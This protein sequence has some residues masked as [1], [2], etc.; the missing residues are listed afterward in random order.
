MQAR[1]FFEQIPLPSGESALATGPR[2]KF[3]EGV[4]GITRSAPKLGEHTVQVLTDNL[5]LTSDELVSLFELG[6][7]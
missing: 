5:G 2:Y 3:T 7:I 4:P 6:V 1:E